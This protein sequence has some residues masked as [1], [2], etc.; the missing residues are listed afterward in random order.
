MSVNHDHMSREE[1]GRFASTEVL[2]GPESKYIYFFKCQLAAAVWK[3]QS[4][5]SAPLRLACVRL[6]RHVRRPENPLAVVPAGGPGINTES[7]QKL[8]IN[9]LFWLHKRN[10]IKNCFFPFSNTKQV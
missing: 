6:C 1:A 5:Q 7:V 8:I 4:G 2:R 9:C 3:F 10:K